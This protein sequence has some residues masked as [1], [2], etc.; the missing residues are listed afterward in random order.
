MTTL[1]SNPDAAYVM[2]SG[3]SPS[4]RPRSRGRR[5]RTGR[6]R[7]YTTPMR[8]GCF[9]TNALNAQFRFIPNA[10]ETN[11]ISPKS[12]RRSLPSNR[13]HGNAKNAKTRS[14]ARHHLCVSCASNPMM[15]PRCSNQPKLAERWF[16]YSVPCG[17]SGPLSLTWASMYFSFNSL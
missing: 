3:F 8:W 17:A 7:S 13:L 15:C 11:S 4:T 5:W 2:R 10:T 6:S 14:W 12:M 16:T 1:T 9:S